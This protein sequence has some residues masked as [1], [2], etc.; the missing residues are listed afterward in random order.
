MK[1]VSKIMNRMNSNSDQKWSEIGFDFLYKKLIMNKI[2]KTKEALN[3]KDNVN[4][5]K[6]M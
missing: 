6:T 3:D 4:V 1:I 5:K 2:K